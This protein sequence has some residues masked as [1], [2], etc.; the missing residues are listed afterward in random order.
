PRKDVSSWLGGV[1]A[2]SALVGTS[3]G[4]LLGD[5]LARRTPGAYFW[6]SGVGMLL[7]APFTVLAL[8]S[9]SYPL[10]FLSIFACLTFGVF[11]FG[12][13]NTILVNV[14][15][16]HIRAAAIALNVL[17]IHWLGDIPS[18]WLVGLV[19]DATRAAGLAGDEKGGLFWG[20]MLMMPAM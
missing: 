14:T 11:N 12:P 15:R 1:V 20:L 2:V 16:P 3:A 17:M 6:V 8:L 4:G 13:S 7:A 10:I 19:S 18:M 5:R 9:H